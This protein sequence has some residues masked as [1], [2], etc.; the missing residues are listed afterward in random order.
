M[1]APTARWLCT[2]LRALRGGV[3]LSSCEM[4]LTDLKENSDPIDFHVPVEAPARSAQ[5]ISDG[6]GLTAAA[7]ARREAVLVQ[8]QI[9][10]KQLGARGKAWSELVRAETKALLAF[11]VEPTASL[12]PLA[13]AFAGQ[14]ANDRSPDERSRCLAAGALAAISV[15]F[16]TTRLS[17]SLGRGLRQLF[18]SKNR[19]WRG[20]VE[21]DF[22]SQT[23]ICEWQGQECE[24]LA[25]KEFAEELKRLVAYPLPDPA[26]VT[27]RTAQDSASAQV[28][29]TYPTKLADDA[30]DVKPTKSGK[31][32]KP[33]TQPR[34]NLFEIQLSHDRFPA[35]SDGYRLSL[36]WNKF[37]PLETLQILKRLNRDL[38]REETPE[39]FK[40]QL[41]AG[42]RYVSIFAG[43]P[44][45]AVWT[46]PLR[47]QGITATMTYDIAGGRIY[48]DAN[49]LAPTRDRGER[50]PRQPNWQTPIPPLA[51][52]VLRAAY[53]RSPDSKTVGDLLA[54]SNI[55][56]QD[57]Q[58]ILWQEWTTSHEPAD[59]RFASSLEPTLRYLG[60][61]PLLAA[62]ISGDTS[63]V[64]P[65]DFYYLAF[66]FSRVWVGVGLFCNWA[67]LEPPTL[68]PADNQRVGSQR[69]P[70]FQQARECV[71]KVNQI[72]RGAINSVTPK[73]GVHE[74]VT[75][76]NQYT[77]C[78]VFQLVMVCIGGRGDRI[79][80]LRSQEIFGSDDYLLIADRNVDKY[81]AR[82][83]VPCTLDMTKTRCSYLQ[84]LLSV[85]K[86]LQAA[87]ATMGKFIVL[88]A[89]GL[90]P[91]APAFWLLEET[92]D[93]GVQRRPLKTADLREFAVKEL[94]LPH[95][96][97]FR[98]FWFTELFNRDVQQMAIESLLGHHIRNAEPHSFSS[99][100]SIRDTGNYL[101]TV[102]Q[103]VHVELGVE[104]LV[105]LG[106][107][108]ARYLRLPELVT[109]L[110]LQPIPSRLL[111]AKI[112]AQDALP[113]ERLSYTQDPPVTR[114]TLVAHAHL[115]RLRSSYL[116]AECP[117]VDTP[118]GALLFCLIA[119]EAV[120]VP[121]EQDLLLRAGLND[122][123]WAIGQ[124]TVIEASEAERPVAQRIIDE[125]TTAALCTARLSD[126]TTSSALVEI[127]E[128][129]L[130][131]LV[132][133]LDENWKP[134]DA[135]Q[136]RALLTTMS[137]HW[138]ALE[139]AP[140][141]MFGVVHKAPF[142][143][144]EHLARLHYGRACTSLPSVVPRLQSPTV[145]VEQSSI[146]DDIAKVFSW[147]VKMDFPHGEDHARRKEI[148]KDLLILQKKW[149]ADIY[150]TALIDL[151]LADQRSDAPYRQI[152]PSTAQDYHPK[153]AIFFSYCAREGT[154]EL[155]PE[156]FAE[157]FQAMGGTPDPTTSG[158]ARSSMLHIC[159]FLSRRGTSCPPGFLDKKG[160]KVARRPRLPVYTSDVEVETVA[161]CLTI[162]FQGRGGTF[163]FAPTQVRLQR[164]VPL[165]A[166]EVRYANTADV[167]PYA[168]LLIVSSSGHALWV[169]SQLIGGG[170]CRF[171][172]PLE[173]ANRRK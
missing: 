37:H 45:H 107:K 7:P 72:A 83:V 136:T 108:A 153:Y 138:C 3:A 90:A 5:L 151:H 130:H 119:R 33:S 162:E 121:L 156:V 164:R 49:V 18:R 103:Q 140:G 65:A 12:H 99:G 101:R 110:R 44:L 143:P 149:D 20:L 55:S 58:D 26:A 134:T 171:R 159:A 93:G 127:A 152:E 105:G 106:R 61:H 47:Q 85:G 19:I 135:K 95:L 137:G 64:P 15:V 38:G 154:F 168:S 125:H 40:F 102:M 145:D 155:D 144:A 116:A 165:R 6:L 35:H 81:S 10:L 43:V 88:S 114:P 27:I 92:A 118:L 23:A 148:K 172:L 89:E 22:L 100:V 123:A 115:C 53:R 161:R 126:K 60:L 67:G 124:L 4:D 66:S 84:H 39:N 87:A 147:W 173:G 117:P 73:S 167:D 104:P 9:G 75:A 21:V 74:I 141:A 113:A 97:S 29:S 56:Y 8:L 69:V 32:R 80:D 48:R 166:S 163:G 51:A 82:R 122:G 46:L 160:S 1:P 142:I 71:Q 76:H 42:A 150:A 25:V 94:G 63:A 86:R 17:P 52:R 2:P 79:A 128:A 11:P 170:S 133:K 28:G 129:Q 132:R 50:V 24:V 96:N 158:P 16:S 169:M 111:T 13:A 78:V 34:L 62:I 31:A 98:H 36:N 120:L 131:E 112:N 157:A 68:D 109:Q 59:G 70:T 146:G 139:V 54:S 57:C 14:V 77:K 41:H 91:E 30:E